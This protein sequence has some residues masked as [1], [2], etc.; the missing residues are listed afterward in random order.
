MGRGR[1][2]SA[3]AILG[4]VVAAGI[5]LEPATAQPKL[6][7]T[8]RLRQD[9]A[10]TQDQSVLEFK[11][12]FSMPQDSQAYLK[13][14][15]K[16]GNPVFAN[17]TVDGDG[18]EGWWTEV[19]L[20]GPGGTLYEGTTTGDPPTGFGDLVSN[21]TYTLWLRAHAPAGTLAHATNYTLDYILAEHV[22]SNATGSGG[23][24]D[25]SVGLHAVV[26]VQGE[27]AALP[28][29]GIPMWVWIVGAAAVLAV[30]AGVVVGVRRA[31]AKGP[32][33]QE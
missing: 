8:T 7:S 5:L 9:V 20:E 6:Q 29:D 23:T 2:A 19:L 18:G 4:L 21:V 12:V 14:S 31:K 11:V 32:G 28:A 15:P 33:P 16:P 1:A 30:A 27:A 13:V 17:G 26:R 10:A 3:W 22:T 25:E 24:L